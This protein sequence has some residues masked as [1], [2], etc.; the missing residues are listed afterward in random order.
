MNEH[1]RKILIISGL[2]LLAMLFLKGMSFDISSMP[3]W[4]IV[5]AII[6]AILLLVAIALLIWLGYKSFKD[7]KGDGVSDEDEHHEEGHEGGHSGDDHHHE[8]ESSRAFI[9]KMVALV[10]TFVVSLAIAIIFIRAYKEV[11]LDKDDDKIAKQAAEQ[12]MMKMSNRVTF[13]IPAGNKGKTIQFTESNGFEY[14]QSYIYNPDDAYKITV[15]T[16]TGRSWDDGPDMP[17][18]EAIG[19]KDWPI[20]IISRQGEIPVFAFERAGKYNK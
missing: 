17:R 14:D 13:R 6:M 5:I 18:G 15:V 3:K 7:E 11:S 20:T 2:S 12:M 19:P 9:A 8:V 1:I 16:A 4:A 10:L